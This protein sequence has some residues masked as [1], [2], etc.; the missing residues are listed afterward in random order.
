MPFA[1]FTTTAGDIANAVLTAGAGATSIP[2]HQNG[3]TGTTSVSFPL[4]IKA[5]A[6]KTGFVRVYDETLNGTVT[7]ASA[8]LPQVTGA[9]IVA[10]GQYDDARP[11]YRQGGGVTNGAAWNTVD[12]GNP[13]WGMVEFRPTIPAADTVNAAS[14]PTFK[15]DANALI[16]LATG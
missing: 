14:V 7:A 5:I 11:W 8:N 4:A 15:V 2:L 3:A 1:T 10:R 13:Q 9:Q 12:Q 6:S 16:V